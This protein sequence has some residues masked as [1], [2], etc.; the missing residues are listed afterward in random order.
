MNHI[1]HA[2]HMHLNAAAVA[3]RT[4]GCRALFLGACAR[5]SFANNVACNFQLLADALVE[6]LQAD[7]EWVHDVFASNWTSVRTFKC[8]MCHEKN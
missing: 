5:A 2:L 8:Q 6:V 3:C 4:L 1:A 7:Y